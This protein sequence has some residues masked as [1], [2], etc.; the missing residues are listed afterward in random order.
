MGD[1]QP[2][3]M[4]PWKAYGRLSIGLNWTF[5]LSITVQEL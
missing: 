2:W 4:A 5:W 1:A 3:L